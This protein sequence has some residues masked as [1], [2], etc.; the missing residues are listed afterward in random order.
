MPQVWAKYSVPVASD[1]REPRQRASRR[2]RRPRPS[3]RS[4]VHGSWLAAPGTARYLLRPGIALGRW[5]T[6]PSPACQEPRLTEMRRCAS[7]AAVK[8]AFLASERRTRPARTGPVILRRPG[9]VQTIPESE[10]ENA[11]SLTTIATALRQHPTHPGDVHVDADGMKALAYATRHIPTVQYIGTV[12]FP[13]DWG[14]GSSAPWPRRRS[15]MRES[16]KG[17]A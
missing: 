11:R 13:H 8:V 4:A 1:R 10:P 5:P 6:R 12:Q 17:G 14:H 2:S 3:G 7:Q 16:K 9:K 15:V